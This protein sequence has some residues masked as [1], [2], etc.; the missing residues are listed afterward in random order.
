MRSTLPVFLLTIVLTGILNFGGY[1]KSP[2][3]V[4]AVPDA[5][6]FAALKAIYDNLGGATW[7][8]KTNWPASGSWPTSATS[9]QFGTG[10]ESRSAME[11][12]QRLFFLVT[13]SKGQSLLI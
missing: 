11:I 5:V 9:A 4:D 3:P 13:I 12:L 2:A 10:M 7:T 1:A 8:T 6:E